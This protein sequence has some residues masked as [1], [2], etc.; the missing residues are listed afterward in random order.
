MSRRP[1][2][3]PRGS[4]GTA[5]PSI[6]HEASPLNRGQFWIFD[7]TY[8]KSPGAT[9]VSFFQWERVRTSGFDWFQP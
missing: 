2:V 1:E 8:R 3:K 9:R 7:A 5:E 6:E 4:A